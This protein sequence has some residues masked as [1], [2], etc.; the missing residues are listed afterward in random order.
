MVNM[1]TYLAPNDKK[2]IKIS[3]VC[4]LGSIFQGGQLQLKTGA[5]VHTID[6]NTGNAVLFPSFYLN[7]F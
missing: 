6:L 1:D 4:E 7:G 3:F 5:D 2:P